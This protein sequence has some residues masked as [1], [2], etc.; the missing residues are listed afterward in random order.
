MELILSTIPTTE[1]GQNGR[2]MHHSLPLPPSPFSFGLI[3]PPPQKQN[4]YPSNT[5]PDTHSFRIWDWYWIRI[6][7]PIHSLISLVFVFALYVK[8]PFWI[9]ISIRIWIWIRIRLERTGPNR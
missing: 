3:Q 5:P 7:H 8:Y 1:T 2:T 6:G 4:K 9:S